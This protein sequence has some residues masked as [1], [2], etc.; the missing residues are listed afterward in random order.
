VFFLL[1]LIGCGT[2][3]QAITPL[4]TKQT[5]TFD[6]TPK[7]DAKLGSTSMVLA[8]IKPSYVSDFRYSSNELFQRFKSGLSGDIEEL[9]IAKG[10]SLKGPYEARDEMVFEDK[11]RIDMAINIEIS[12]GFSSIEGEWIAKY[13]SNLSLLGSST[14]YYTYSY[15]GK[16][17]MTGKINISGVEPLTN[18]KI[19]S[20]SV[21]IPNIEN[22]SI[23]TQNEYRSK[24]TDAQLI[25]DPAVYNALGTALQTQYAGIMEKV[26]AHFNVE[27]LKSL[28]SQIKEL[29]S[30]KGF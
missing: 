28:Q 25:G 27:E 6:Y 2:T 8:F 11:K 22:I 16:I 26:A 10:F 19:W 18:E 7:E 4:V 17:S 3:K 23:A 15:T 14:P 1:F 12:P 30:K 13:H 21:L 29:K 20:K 9:I 5:F 24:Q